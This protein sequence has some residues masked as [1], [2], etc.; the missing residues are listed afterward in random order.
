M[1]QTPE[2][3]IRPRGLQPTYKQPTMI[4]ANTI[5]C[6]YIFGD[7]RQQRR[8]EAFGSAAHA[9]L[10]SCGARLRPRRGGA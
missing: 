10:I 4:S 6:A 9:T 8:I 2:G 1:P 7:M 5:K 3:N